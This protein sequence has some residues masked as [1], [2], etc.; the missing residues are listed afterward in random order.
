M[1]VKTF[2]K[3]NINSVNNSQL[4]YWSG[5]YKLK[6]VFWLKSPYAE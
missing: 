3:F 2:K 1:Y 4:H 5:K 6:P